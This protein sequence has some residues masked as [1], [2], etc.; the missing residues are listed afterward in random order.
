MPNRCSSGGSCQ[1]HG[2]AGGGGGMVLRACVQQPWQLGG[3]PTPRK[4]L[5]RGERVRTA[6]GADQPVKA[7][8]SVPGDG[9]SN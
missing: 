7:W 5:L 3:R 4:G 6:E 8:N 1:D 2:G 9:E